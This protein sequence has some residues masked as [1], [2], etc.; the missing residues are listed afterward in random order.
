LDSALVAACLFESRAKAQEAIDAG[1]VTVD[2]R[3]AH[4]ASTPVRP[5]TLL[6]A[7]APYPWVSRG[8]V[9][10]AA[11]LDHFGID[12]A[13]RIC[14]DVG[15]STGGF[16]HVLLDRGAARIYAVDVGTGQLHPR[17]AGDPRVSDR[18]GTDIRGLAAGDFV[19]APDLVVL[20]VSFISLRLVLPEALTLA[21]PSSDVV[22]LVKP[23][24]EV[25][26][27]NTRRGV[28]RDDALRRSA[29]QSIADLLES[30]G[31]RVMGL[32]LS[33]IAGGDGN[34][35]FLLAARRG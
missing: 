19:P 30:L 10:L 27:G 1:L 29:C 15:A 25:G 28:V 24:F 16:S 33:P 21:A 3:V 17:I 8:G 26:R 12:P 2:G 35:E 18:S 34:V 7:A 31:W 6:A 22:A 4:K 5:G 13:G 20:D 14:L 11:G 23:Q 32:V 9:K